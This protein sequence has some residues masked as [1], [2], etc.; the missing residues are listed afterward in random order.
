MKVFTFLLFLSVSFSSF[1]L[2]AQNNDSTPS[3]AASLKINAGYLSNGVYLGRSDT[4]AISSVIPGLTYTLKSGFFFSGSVNYVPSRQFNKLDG[5]S[6]ETGYTYDHKDLSIGIVLSKYFSSFSS[7]EIISAINASLG[8]ELTY[9]FFNTVSPSV[10]INYALGKGGGGSDFIFN[11]GLSHE[12]AIKKIFNLHDQLSITPSIQL[13]AGTQNFYSSYF[14]R[15]SKSDKIRKNYKNSH[16]AKG[17]AKSGIPVSAVV[18]TPGTGTQ[19]NINQRKFQILDYE[20]ALPLSYSFH[21]FTLEMNPIYAVA[22]HKF[23][24]AGTQTTNVANSSIFYLEAG[25]SLK[26]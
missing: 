15:K 12:F 2:H 4:A 10:K 11:G 22:V 5:G 1:V 8:A 6:L 14:I 23:I 18:V 7:T 24:D 26:F 21:H 9:N 19:V 25:L 17:S 3:H 20:Y 13:N 16:S